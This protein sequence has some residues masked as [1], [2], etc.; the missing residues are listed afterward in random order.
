M[1]MASCG[2]LDGPVTV[3]GCAD[4]AVD[5]RLGIKVGSPFGQKPAYFRPLMTILLDSQPYPPVAPV[6]R[7]AQFERASAPLLT[8]LQPAAARQIAA[9]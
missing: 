3:A 2:S 7:R 9:R 4:G 6:L 8:A 5:P 1:L